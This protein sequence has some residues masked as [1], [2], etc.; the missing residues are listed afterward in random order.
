MYIPFLYFFFY[1]FILPIVHTAPPGFGI[2]MCSLGF[3]IYGK[4]FLFL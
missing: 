4:S 3:F 1:L 2:R